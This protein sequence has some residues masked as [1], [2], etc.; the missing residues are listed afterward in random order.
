MVQVHK[1]GRKIL[2]GGE[3]AA[4]IV[5]GIVTAKRIGTVTEKGQLGTQGTMALS[6]RTQRS[7]IRKKRVGVGRQRWRSTMTSHW[8]WRKRTRRRS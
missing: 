8:S 3:V 6:K 7:T 5:T 2:A 4:G 1:L